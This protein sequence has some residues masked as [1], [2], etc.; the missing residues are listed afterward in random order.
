MSI[1]SFVTLWI[2]GTIALTIAA[3][4]IYKKVDEFKRYEFE[5]QD[6]GATTFNTYEQAKSFRGAQHRWNYLLRLVG[7]AAF[8]GWVLT[9]VG[10]MISK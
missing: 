4:F 6:G 10:Y 5:N 9:V 1:E 2:L 8:I 3:F 7:G